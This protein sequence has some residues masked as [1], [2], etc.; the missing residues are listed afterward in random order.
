MSRLKTIKM[1]IGRTKKRL[2]EMEPWSS[3]TAFG[4]RLSGKNPKTVAA[5]NAA[6]QFVAR[7]GFEAAVA[8]LP[9]WCK[10]GI[11]I[12]E[13]PDAWES[14]LRCLEGYVN[15]MEWKKLL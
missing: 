15:D 13:V 14:N 11:D 9:D 1:I 8:E 6:R 12:F 5:Q 7:E 10:N 4:C 2:S 3:P